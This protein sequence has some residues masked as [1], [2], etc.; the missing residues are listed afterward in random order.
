[1]AGLEYE[2]PFVNDYHYHVPPH[3]SSTVT[4]LSVEAS[5]SPTTRS[6]VWR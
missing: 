5:G 6:R 4:L 2:I 3:S 1:M